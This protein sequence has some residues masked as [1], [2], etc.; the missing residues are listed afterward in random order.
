MNV[1][2]RLQLNLLIKSVSGISE[3]GKIAEVV[4]PMIWFE[5]S[6]YID[7]PVL[8]TFRTNLV[9]LPMVM[10]YMQYI[11]IALG[12]AGILGAVMLY[13]NDK[14][15]SRLDDHPSADVNPSSSATE[16]TPLLRTPES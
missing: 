7:G 4:M 2:I 14:E 15:K 10:E 6:G 9:V 5:E 3:T 12:L 1:S 16:K 8:N 11:F 13:V